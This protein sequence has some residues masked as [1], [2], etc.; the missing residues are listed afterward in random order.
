MKR[1]ATVKIL[2]FGVL[3]ATSHYITVDYFPITAR[4]QVSDSSN[5]VQSGKRAHQRFFLLLF[6]HTFI[7]S[8]CL[9]CREMLCARFW[10]GQF[11]RV[12]AN[13]PA[14]HAAR[15]DRLPTASLHSSSSSPSPH[16]TIQPFSIDCF[17]F[18]YHSCKCLEPASSLNGPLSVIDGMLISSWCFEYYIAGQIK[19]IV[20]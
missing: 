15:N 2:D 17:A 19:S 10:D 6:F 1:C 18:L 11:S 16:V 14:H 7:Y 3:M 20:V 9:I 12:S 5:S 13:T 4:P 8:L